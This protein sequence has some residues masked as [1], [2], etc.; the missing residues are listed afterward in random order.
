M[1]LFWLQPCPRFEAVAEDQAGCRRCYLRKTATSPTCPDSVRRAEKNR[2]EHEGRG[3]WNGSRW[4]KWQR[5]EIMRP[6]QEAAS[7]VASFFVRRMVTI[8]LTDVPITATVEIRQSR[9]RK[10]RRPRDTGW[11]SECGARGQ[12]LV[13]FALGRFG[14]QPAGT[15]TGARGARWKWMRRWRYI[16]RFW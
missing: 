2:R 7:L 14:H 1:I 15:M 6:L 3:Y 16:R 4:T 10:G 11:W 12:G 5:I 8:T 13:T 9:S